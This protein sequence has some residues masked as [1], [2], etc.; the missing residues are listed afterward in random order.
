MA[1]AAERHYTGRVSIVANVVSMFVAIAPYWDQTTSWLN[2]G[3]LP[4]FHAYLSLGL[5]FGVVAFLSYLGGSKMESDFYTASWFL[6][7]S[8]FAGLVCLAAAVVL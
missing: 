1:F 4:F 3:G 7:N 6:F 5:L 2:L 8:V